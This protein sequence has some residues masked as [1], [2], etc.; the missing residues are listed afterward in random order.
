MKYTVIFQ[1]SGR[2]CEVEEG[3]SLLD[4]ARAAGERINA[5]CGGQ[6]VCGKCRVEHVEGVLGPAGRAEQGLLDPSELAG[7]IRLACQV[8]VHSDSAVNVPEESSGESTVVLGADAGLEVT[9]DPVIK[10]LYVEP[11]ISAGGG[12]GAEAERVK[13]ALRQKYGIDGISFTLTALRSLHG[14]L[15]EGKGGLTAYLRDGREVVRLVPGFGPGLYGASFDVGT[16]TI[17]A[18]LCELETGRLLAT[19]AITNPLVVMGDDVLSRVSYAESRASGLEDMRVLLLDALNGML[20]KMSER[21][22]PDGPDGA[23]GIIE[24]VLVGNTVMHHIL[25]GLP[26]GQLGVSPFVPAVSGGLNIPATD[27]GLA[28]SDNAR[29]YVPPVAGGF[30]GADTTAVMADLWP[31]DKGMATLV[32]DLGTNGELVLVHGGGV[33]AASCATGPALEGA[34]ISSGMRAAPG[35]IE[36]AVVDPDSGEVSYRVIGSDVWSTPGRY[37][38]ARGVCGSGII[39]LVAGMRRVGVLDHGGRILL[40]AGNPR[41]RTGGRGEPEFVVAYA[42]ETA[43]GNEIALTQSDIRA[44]Q[45][46]KAAVAAGV[47]I[48]MVEARVAGP[49]RLVVAGAFGNYLDVWNAASIGM[50]PGCEPKGSLQAG[51][52]AG[53]G[54]RAL[55]LSSDKRS[56]AE[57]LANQV[58]YLELST[59]PDFQDRFMESMDLP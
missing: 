22:A 59:H 47:G 41:A 2:R 28:I 19:D 34:Q 53:D 55:L 17:A 15:A 38:G 24:A 52:A 51:N 1:P 43:S 7:G 6:G 37:T 50:F 57:R 44:V 12:P 5:L 35:A 20:A 27:L 21:S 29:V 42:S 58:V 48:L 8:S 31:L 3:E 18:T 26:T 13:D 9:V 14:V 4:A 46:A 23:D 30:V 54:A 11:V 40:D 10:N 56:E 33:M 45:L 16:T 32:A 49:W 36:K 39:D 25:L